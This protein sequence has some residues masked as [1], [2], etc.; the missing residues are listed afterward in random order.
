MWLYTWFWPRSFINFTSEWPLVTDLCSSA[1]KLETGVQVIIV[2]L[3]IL[4][5]IFKIYDNVYHAVPAVAECQVCAYRAYYVWNKS[6]YL[7]IHIKQGCFFHI[8]VTEP[9]SSRY[10]C[11]LCTLEHYVA[12]LSFGNCAS[13]CVTEPENTKQRAWS[14]VECT[15]RA[16]M[17]PQCNRCNKINFAF[18]TQTLSSVLSLSRVAIT[19]RVVCNIAYYLSCLPVIALFLSN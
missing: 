8:I 16:T 3:V 4:R 10:I 6:I 13:P 17:H 11:T 19:R 7:Y 9:H 1:N 12:N 2:E 5:W 18:D 15:R 14:F